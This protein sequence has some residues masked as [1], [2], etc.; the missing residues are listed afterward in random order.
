VTHV[1]FRSTIGFSFFTIHVLI[2]VFGILLLPSR[3]TYTELALAGLIVTPLAAS[4]VAS[5]VKSSRRVAKVETDL[6]H[7]IVFVV[8]CFLLMAVYGICILALI[9][10][11]PSSLMSIEQ[12]LLF[13]GASNA[14]AA[15]L[16][17]YIADAAF[18]PGR[19]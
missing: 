11:F 2:L 9:F 1:A 19:P 7:P 16:I 17:S 12:F 6:K 3:L 13:L 5:F 10:Y 8:A 18:W 15:G 4:Y 14:A